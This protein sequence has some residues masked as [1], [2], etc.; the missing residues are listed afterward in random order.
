MAR[1]FIQSIRDHLHA[2]QYS[3]R[4]EQTYIYWIADYIRFHK[5]RHPAELNET[6]I[7]AYL[8][9]LALH[10][11]DT[12]HPKNGSQFTDVPVPE[13]VRQQHY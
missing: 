10:R 12:L 1:P 2:R 4:T 6:D 13:S 3:K 9:Y 5:M 11:N 7:V 8:E